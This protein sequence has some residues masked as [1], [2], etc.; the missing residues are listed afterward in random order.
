MLRQKINSCRNTVSTT[1]S[2]TKHTEIG[3]SIYNI[4]NAEKREV[5]I[6]ETAYN[7]TY[8]VLYIVVFKNVSKEILRQDKG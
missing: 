1:V 2:M 6:N 3:Y 7:T 8:Y 4:N 5:R